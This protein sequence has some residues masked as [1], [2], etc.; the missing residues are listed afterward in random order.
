MR[1]IRMWREGR[2]S[3]VAPTQ[4]AM[5][6][7]NEEMRGAMPDTIWVSGCDS[8]YLGKDGRPE[9]WP[10]T[11]ERH[12]AMLRDPDPAEFELTNSQS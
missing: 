6:R 1:W 9:V 12:R 2:L 11:P 4:A 5:T 10:W 7:F 8:W 3:K